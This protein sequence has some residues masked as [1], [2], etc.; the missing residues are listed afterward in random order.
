MARCPPLPAVR[1]PLTC[2]PMTP[3][4]FSGVRGRPRRVISAGQGRYDVHRRPSVSATVRLA[5]LHALL[6]AATEEPHWQAPT[7]VHV[8][9][10]RL[11]E[12]IE[13]TIGCA[14]RGQLA[15]GDTTAG[16]D[17]SGAPRSSRRTSPRSLAGKAYCIN[18]HWPTRG[19]S[20]LLTQT[21]AAT[22]NQHVKRIDRAARAD[23]RP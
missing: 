4:H 23:A 15:G 16:A 9:S 13:L 1:Q 10:T 21:E 14:S 8:P 6:H 2:D 22:R 5:L 17:G 3:R 7:E 18:Q 11:A 12:Q 19:C 20:S